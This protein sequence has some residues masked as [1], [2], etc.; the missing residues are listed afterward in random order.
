MNPQEIERR[1]YDLKL[2]KNLRLPQL[3]VEARYGFVGKSGRCIL[4]APGTPPGPPGSSANCDPTLEG[5]FSHS[6]EDF[7][8]S[9]G[10]DNLSVTALF[11]IPLGNRTA[12]KRVTQ[13]KI[14]LRRATTL[15]RQ[16]EQQIIVDVRRAARTLD[17][18]QRGI[19]AS[20]RRK[21]AAAEQLR[22]EKIRLEHGESTPFDVLLKERDF[23]ESESQNISALKLYRNAVTFLNRQ[24][25]TI[26]ELNNVNIEEV[27]TL[28]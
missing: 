14:E 12:S 7:F 8:T 19:S 18:A 20:E 22:A 3:D 21:A 5:G 4:R 26:L 1:A 6:T 11:S 25:G 27:A 2:A 24:Q 10:A 15:E 9:R 28:R 13:R 16:L 23:V 17:A